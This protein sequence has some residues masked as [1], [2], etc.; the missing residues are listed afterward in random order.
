MAFHIAMLKIMLEEKSTS[1]ETLSVKVF[2]EGWRNGRGGGFGHWRCWLPGFALN[3][4]GHPRTNL[5][6]VTMGCRFVFLISA[7][8]FQ[9]ALRLQRDAGTLGRCLIQLGHGSAVLLKMGCPA[10]PRC[11]QF[12]RLGVSVW[13]FFLQKPKG[14]AEPTTALLQFQ[15]PEQHFPFPSNKEKQCSCSAQEMPNADQN[16]AQFFFLAQHPAAP[17]PAAGSTAD[18]SSP[19]DPNPLPA[20]FPVGLPHVSEELE[21]LRVWTMVWEKLRG[22]TQPSSLEDGQAGWVPAASV[23]RHTSVLSLPENPDKELPSNQSLV[24]PRESLVHPPGKGKFPPQ[25]GAEPWACAACNSA[26]ELMGMFCRIRT[27]KLSDTGLSNSHWAPLL[28]CVLLG[29][30]WRTDIY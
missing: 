15:S 9:E 11:L 25:M 24:A 14:F 20:R 22:E 17:V 6:L 27:V 29:Q 30:H 4:P 26:T 1:C 21:L 8:L 28:N 7:G 16:Q 23:N 13:L 5:L 3:Q 2:K 18:L 19:Q 10:V 12:V